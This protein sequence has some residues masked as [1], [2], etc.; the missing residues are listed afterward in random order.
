M[1]VDITEE[2][3]H[4]ARR[5]PYSELSCVNL[6]TIGFLQ[7]VLFPH[8]SVRPVPRGRK[9]AETEVFMCPPRNLLLRNFHN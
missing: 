9:G 1:D 2:E 4:L 3:V 6:Q 8:R 7:N 5:G